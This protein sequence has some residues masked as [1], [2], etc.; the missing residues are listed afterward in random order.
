MYKVFKRGDVVLADL[1]EVKDKE[2]GNSVQMGVRP[3]IVTSNDSGNTYGTILNVI[4][5]SSA[6]T[7]LIKVLP[8]HVIFTPE[9]SSVKMISVSMAEQIT[10][11]DLKQVKKSKPLFTLN[12]DL[13]RKVDITILIQQGLSKYFELANLQQ[14]TYAM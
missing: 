7:K 1:G 11:I 6:S 14:I 3:C 12:D 10:T 2:T 9:N 5:L 8:T 13:M 4:P